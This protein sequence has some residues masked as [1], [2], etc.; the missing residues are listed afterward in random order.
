M[1]LSVRVALVFVGCNSRVGV[2]GVSVVCGVGDCVIVAIAAA[3]TA[4]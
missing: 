3:V 4:A 2:S 1:I